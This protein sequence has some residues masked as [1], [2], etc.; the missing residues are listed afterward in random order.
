MAQGH[1]VDAPRERGYAAD[2]TES[3]MHDFGHRV[4]L[5]VVARVVHDV[6]DAHM[7]P[8]GEPVT[9]ALTREA[10]RRLRRLVRAAD[11]A[12]A[13]P[14]RSA[15]AEAIARALEARR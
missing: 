5:D 9:E 15:R 1:L 12:A 3:L 4:G 2:L 13:P 6:L 11:Q 14:Q 10:V 7:H 8:R